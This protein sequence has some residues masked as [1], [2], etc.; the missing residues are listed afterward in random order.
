VALWVGAAVHLSYEVGF[1]KWGLE[2]WH[3]ASHVPGVL[4]LVA[5]VVG[6]VT[7]RWS[8]TWR[9]VCVGGIA[10]VIIAL[11]ITEM[12][13]R[14]DHHGPWLTAARWARAHTAKESVFAMTD[15][16]LFGYFSGRRTVNLDGVIN[17]YAFQ[18]ALSEGRLSEFLAESGVTHLADYEVPTP[19]PAL[20]RIRLRSGLFGGPVSEL[21][22]SPGA[23]IY[24]SKPYEDHVSKLY[25]R[26]SISFVIWD[27]SKIR[28]VGD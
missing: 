27:F 12:R 11:G 16:G 15:S 3:F 14:G 21:Q 7:T 1:T 9:G 8:A 20:Y 26:G 10:V 5:L 6:S 4:F 25:G 19:V 18:R 13:L 17:S 24:R 28:I 23:E 2:W 22:A